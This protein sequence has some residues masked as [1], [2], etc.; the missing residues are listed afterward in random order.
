L[1]QALSEYAPRLERMVS[2]RM[3]ARHRRRFE[4]ADV[5]Q[6]ALLEATKRFGEWS[7]GSSYPFHL[8]LRLLAAQSL[9][10][11][12]RLYLQQKREAGRERGLGP[13]IGRATASNAA[14]WFVSTHTSPTQAARRAELRDLVREALE[15]LDELDREILTLRHFEQLSNEETAAELGIEP[16]AAS[17]RFTRALQRIRPALSA[18][19]SDA[20]HRGP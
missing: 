16:A 7:S 2:L 19:E 1:S 14:E 20:E 17:K 12:E 10:K 6:D 8:W 15:Q 18:L 3:D 9:S 5:V 4:P 11:A 13:P